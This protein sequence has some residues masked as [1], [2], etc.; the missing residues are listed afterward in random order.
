MV[1]ILEPQHNCN[2]QIHVIT[3]CVIKGQHCTVCDEYGFNIAG[4]VIQRI[5]VCTLTKLALLFK[6]FMLAQDS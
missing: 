6:E 2:I 3:R 4:S 5:H 1:K